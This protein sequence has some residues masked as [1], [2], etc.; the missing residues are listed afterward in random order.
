MAGV[1]VFATLLSVMIILYSYV[2]R[3][4]K[5]THIMK[6]NLNDSVLKPIFSSH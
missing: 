5:L 4:L 3:N 2:A 6:Q 1:N